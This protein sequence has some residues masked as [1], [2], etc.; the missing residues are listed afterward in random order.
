MVPVKGWAS[1]LDTVGVSLVHVQ[2]LEG[3]LLLLQWAC[4][5]LLPN[6]L[7]LHW[8]VDLWNLSGWAWDCPLLSYGTLGCCLHAFLCEVLK[9]PMPLQLKHSFPY[10]GQ[11]FMG[12]CIHIQSICFFVLSVSWWIDEAAVI[13][14]RSVHHFSLVFWYYSHWD[15]S[16]LK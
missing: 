12:V 10:A 4:L 13:V 9:Q 7:C 5:L 14:V 2:S 6:L 8:L 15:L 11:Y 1:L 3:L 16:S